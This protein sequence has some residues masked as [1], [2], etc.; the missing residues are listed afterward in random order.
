M[1]I[2][3]LSNPSDSPSPPTVLLNFLNLGRDL[4]AITKKDGGLELP[5]GDADQCQRG[6]IRF[7][8]AEPRQ[9]AKPQQTVSHG[10]AKWR[11]RSV[12]AVKR[13]IVTGQRCEVRHI[14]S[15]DFSPLAQPAIAD[16]HVLKIQR[17]GVGGRFQ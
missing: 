7:F 17:L 8:A 10:P 2:E 16:T 14:A 3:Q 6:N 9:N 13:I 12:I 4:Y 5:I 11:K 15:D 1:L